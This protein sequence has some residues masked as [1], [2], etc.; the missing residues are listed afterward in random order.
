MVMELE[1]TLEECLGKQICV[2]VFQEEDHVDVATEIW[3]IAKPADFEA[4]KNDLKQLIES[5][6]LNEYY[7]C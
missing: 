7:I 5:D 6:M 4:F 2:R 1:F 3:Q